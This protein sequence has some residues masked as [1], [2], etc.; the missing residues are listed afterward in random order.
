[1]SR[2][3]VLDTLWA[4]EQP[5]LPPAPLNLK[6]GTPCLPDHAALTGVHFVLQLGIPC[7]MLPQRISCGLTCW[8]RLRDW[9]EAGVWDRLQ[10]VCRAVLGSAVDYGSTLHLRQG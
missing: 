4:V 9:Q 6:G 5:L 3:L 10:L 2:P 7:E 8:C 1:M